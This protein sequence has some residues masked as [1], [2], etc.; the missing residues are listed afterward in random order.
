MEVWR[1]EPANAAQSPYE[2]L[3]VKHRISTTMRQSWFKVDMRQDI[4]RLTQ[5]LNTETR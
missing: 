2:K 4:I 5:I 1:Q 3:E